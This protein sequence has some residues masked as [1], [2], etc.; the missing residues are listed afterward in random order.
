MDGAM[1][2]MLPGFRRHFLVTPGPGRVCAAVE[3]DYHSM[4][5]TLH[6][7]G[8]RVA[9]VEPVMERAPWTTCPGAPDVLRATFAGV[10]LSDVAARGEK[11]A[12]CTHLHDLAVLAAAHAGDAMPTRYEILACDPVEDGLAVAEIRRDGA[13]LV[14][15]AHRGHVM[16]APAEITGLSLMKL[17]PWID[18]LD[19]PLREAARLLQWGAILANGRS[20]PMERQST[21]TRVPPNCFTFQPE[22]AVK[23]VRVGRVIDFSAD[24][25]MPLDHFDGATYDGRRNAG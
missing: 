8:V 2:D 5:V 16:T 24:A 4:A 19:E 13:P 15:I 10:A 18:G 9:R 20:I 7:D 23:A 6:H 11:K 17:R 21:A 14:Q 12:N 25:R 1:L 22:N 3:D